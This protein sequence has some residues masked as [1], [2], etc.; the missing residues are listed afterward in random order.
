MARAVFRLTVLV[1][2]LVVAAVAQAHGPGDA[3]VYN[4]LEETGAA[5]EDWIIAALALAAI[6]YAAGLA[7]LWH[8]SGRGRGIRLREAFAFVAGWMALALALLGPLDAFAGRSFAVHMAQHEAL[9]LIAAPLLVRGRPLAVWAWAL[10]ARSRAATHRWLTQSAWR[11]VWRTCTRP[12]GA[13]VLQLATLFAWHLPAWFDSAVTHAGV[14]ALQH[15]SFLTA[16]LCFWWAV[17]SGAPARA[18]SRAASGIAL[19]C[20]FVTTLATGALGALL[21]F[22]SMPWYRAYADGAAWGLS[23]LED[24]Q[25]G[26][27]LMWVPGGVAYLAA[28]L[29]HAARILGYEH[30]PARREA[31]NGA[32]MRRPARLAR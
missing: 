19:V 13:T 31:R 3:A 12:L 16:A 10:S 2:V 32:A 15:A 30:P 18:S 25:L 26:G 8:A 7:R 21:T 1:A 9:M 29:V 24:Q 28:A 22:A 20:M 5:G 23:A 11:H 6:A 27:L 14:H 4:R 17:R